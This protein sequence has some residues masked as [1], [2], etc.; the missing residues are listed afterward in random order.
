VIFRHKP[1]KTPGCQFLKFR[2]LFGVPPG[3]KR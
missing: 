2:Y 3:R 1:P